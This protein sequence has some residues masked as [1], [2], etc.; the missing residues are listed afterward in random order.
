[1]DLSHPLAAAAR[2]VAQQLG[3]RRSSGGDVP[4][5]RRAS[6]RTVARR[7]YAGRIVEPAAVVG[8]RGHEPP[9]GSEA[10]ADAASPFHPGDQRRVADPPAKLSM[11]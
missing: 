6:A 8:F 7:Q 10:G 5:A 4:A 1:M 9:R 11:D 3:S 2:C